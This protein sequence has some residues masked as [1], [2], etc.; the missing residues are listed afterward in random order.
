MRQIRQIAFVPE[1]PDVTYARLADFSSYPEL[2]PSVLRVEVSEEI[3][4]GGHR[5]S[6]RSAWEVAFRNGILCWTEA[7]VFDYDL[8]TVAFEQVEGDLE[9]LRG[10]WSVVAAK[11]GSEIHFEAEFDLGLPGLEDFLEPVAQRALENNVRELV[12]RLFES[13]TLEEGEEAADGATTGS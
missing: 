1:T 3:R 4:A 11:T 8:R 6:C 5:K 7:D 2:A 9:V 10:R 13:S 12:T